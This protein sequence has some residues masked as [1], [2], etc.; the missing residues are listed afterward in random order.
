M[1]AALLITACLL[2]ATTGLAQPSQ[3]PR[4]ARATYAESPELE[5]LPG[6]KQVPAGVWITGPLPPPAVISLPANQLAPLPLPGVSSR[7]GR[8]TI[9][10]EQSAGDFC[11]GHQGPCAEWVAPARERRRRLAQLVSPLF[12]LR[13][14]R[15]VET[16]ARAAAQQLLPDDAALIPRDAPRLHTTGSAFGILIPWSAL[17]PRSGFR[18]DRISISWT[19]TA[20]GP[21]QHFTLVLERPREFHYG[22]CDLPPLVPVERSNQPPREYSPGFYLPQAELELDTIWAWRDPDDFW[23]WKTPALL[24]FAQNAASVQL[25]ST[26]GWICWPL[27]KFVNTRT[28]QSTQLASLS[29]APGPHADLEGF[30]I[31]PPLPD[32]R[33]QLLSRPRRHVYGGHSLGYCGGSD[34]VSWK[35]ISLLPERPALQTAAERYLR[36]ACDS[37]EPVD[38]EVEFSPDLKTITEYEALGLPYQRSKAHWRS[39]TIVWRDGRYREGPWRSVTKPAQSALER[40]DKRW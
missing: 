24:P 17:P 7:W 18:L 20:K 19:H 29:N 13:E 40:K 10:P 36:L 16:R 38:Y 1:H 3:R 6:F 23:L 4:T 31:A 8:L 9:Q 27:L 34:A 39:R 26:P 33:I 25:E 35:I 30:T 5:R 28:G 37:G 14:D 32:G 12:E 2:A 15:Y 22:R 11:R 21:W